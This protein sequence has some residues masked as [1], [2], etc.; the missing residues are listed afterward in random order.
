MKYTSGKVIWGEPIRVRIS[1]ST[2]TPAVG[3][4]QPDETFDIQEIKEVYPKNPNLDFSRGLSPEH[5]WKTAQGWILAMD[6]NGV[7]Y[8]TKI[9]NE[10]IK[11][12]VTSEMYN[13]LSNAVEETT[14]TSEVYNRTMQLFGLPYQ[15]LNSV[16]PRINS[17]NKY[18]GRN[19]I[20]R[21]LN[22]APVATIIPGDPYYLP[23][24]SKDARNTF[25]D[26]F[27]Q[28][29]AGTLDQIETL[30]S[31]SN[32]ETS[33]KNDKIRLYDFKANYF[34][35]IRYV[36]I[37]CRSCAD[38]L[39]I[40]NEEYKYISNRNSSGENAWESMNFSDFDWKNYRWNGA[41]Y[42]SMAINGAKAA[43]K[44]IGDAA[45]NALTSTIK[46]IKQLGSSA[47]N[48]ITGDK[49]TDKSKKSNG[50]LT[51]AEQQRI[52]NLTNPDTDNL[53][54]E[55]SDGLEKAFRKVNFVQ[56]YTNPDGTGVDETFSN[57]SGSPGIKSTLEDAAT[58]LKDLE[59]LTSTA[60]ADETTDSLKQ[61]ASD[62][63]SG[64]SSVLNL[65][66]SGSNNIESVLARIT[67]I[68]SN[69]ITGANVIM[70]DIY[71]S[72]KYSK[73]YDLSV[74]LKALYGNKVSY[75]MDILVPTMHLLAL[76]L[77]RQNTANTYK[78]PFLVKVFVD[79]LF[80]CNLGLV[81]SFS[82]NKTGVPESRNID[83]LYTEWEIR[84]SITDLY[85]DLTMTPSNHP[86]L[87]LNNSSLVDY[88]SINCGL[89]F[90]EPRL[91]KKL[92]MLVS[93]VKNIAEEYIPN[94]GGKVL[95]GLDNKVS[96]LLHI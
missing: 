9:V 44:Y 64:A 32:D 89:N 54:R 1:Y 84:L 95:E 43:T 4:F 19:Y 49:K 69:L 15:F 60:G 51:T 88:L 30:I 47:I 96:S 31:D 83:G 77:P 2:A 57:D 75:Y 5:W 46:K 10:E 20:N 21:I 94:I 63:M 85:S 35:Y 16:D 34:E 70:P 3:S 91:G 28:A 56:F 48:L 55:E 65:D 33:S 68:G 40:S 42:Q 24:V 93:G 50:K 81:T 23:G 59:F 6:S 52:L 41:G 12:A 82:I 90:L 72:S 80:T 18:V 27:L 22:E 38:L 92:S 14:A 7:E 78:A 39:G 71:Q 26:A 29:A 25:T 87:F 79:G 11:Q 37:L 74:T 62:I 13:Q 58:K 61:F 76:V 67:D 86:L 73:S 45:E 66:S 53:D 17:I 8:A 36:N